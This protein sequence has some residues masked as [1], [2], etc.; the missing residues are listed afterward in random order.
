MRIIAGSL[1]GREI[2]TPQA[3]GT[4]P[5]M[6]KT[7]EALFSM[8]EARGIEWDKIAVLDL[9]AGTGS[10][11]L[12]ALSRGASNATFVDNSAELIKA[13]SRNIQ[14][15][16]LAAKCL[17][18]RQ[19]ALRFLARSSDRQYQLVFVDPP[20]RRNFAKPVL[21][22][23]VAKNWLAPGAFVIG[24][25]ENGLEFDP[26]AALELITTRLF[27]QTLLKVWE[28]NESSSLS[29]DI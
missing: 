16:N 15:L 19:D 29:G 25:L 11:G 7:R 5:A 22:R 21:E 6:G 13:M 8:L 12:E 20:Y 17:L 2:R 24:E 18:V 26:P 4:R 1:A 3:S 28:F 27:G 14:N 23:L 10:L 9:F